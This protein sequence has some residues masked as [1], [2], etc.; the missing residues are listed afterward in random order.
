VGIAHDIT[1]RKLAE[2]ELERAKEAAEA[3]NE[4]KGQFLANMSHEIRTPMNAILNMTK[5]ALEMARD[6][7]QREHLELAYNAA[8]SLLLIINDILDFSKI[9]A[10]KMDL[11]LTPFDPRTKL[12]LPLRPLALH[13]QAKGLRYVCRVQDSVPNV[14]IGDAGRLYQVLLNLVGNAIKFTPS[15]SV[16]ID[17]SLHGGGEHATLVGRV[18]DTGIG[19][20]PPKQASIF[21]PFSQ[22]DTSITRRY[23]GTGLG[24][25][26]CS[27]LVRL[28]DGTLSVDSQPGRG[29]TF[30]FTAQVR[31]G[32]SAELPSVGN[33]SPT[34]TKSLRILLAEDSPD[35]QKVAQELLLRLNHRCEVAENGQQAIQMYRR[36]AYDLILMDIQMPVM[37][38]F[39]ATSAIRTLERELQRPHIP[40]IALTAHA[41]KGDRETCLARGMDGYVP[42][43]ID[44]EELAAAIG[45]VLDGREMPTFPTR[46]LPSDFDP[47]VALSRSGDAA[48][49]RQRIRIFLEGTRL[50]PLR[51]ALASQD[52]A[53]VR[54]AAHNFKG[55][56][57]LFSG[58]AMQ[59]ASQLEQLAAS[60]NL[61]EAWRIFHALEQ[62][63]DR[64]EIDL[65]RWLEAHPE[66]LS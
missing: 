31:R 38:G 40:I 59:E 4:A 54:K 62:S 6:P 33:L 9:E 47:E 61:T 24:L 30:T 60:G 37:G 28:M 41:M 53:V 32:Q 57:G 11:D 18:T 48:M 56:V 36:E 17:L 46:S 42:K 49:L 43:P 16:E 45:A 12:I 66:T 10:G 51:D 29:S 63:V 1:E 58:R 34:P 7:V 55:F 23:G 39:E 26:I 35:N 44:L 27:R 14:L 19:I 2:E 50:Q 65:R 21:Q 3:A 20:D 15:G 5:F 13:A 64:L 52:V 8:D 25:A 22:G